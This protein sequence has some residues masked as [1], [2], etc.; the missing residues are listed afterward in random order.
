MAASPTKRSMDYARKRGW[1]PGVVERWIPQVRRRS[2]LF[3]GIDLVL[4]DDQPGL[5]GVQAT[6]GSNVAARVTKLSG[7]DDMHT[8]LERGLRLEVWGWRKAGPRGK[9]KRWAV[10]RVRASLT[11]EGAIWWQEVSE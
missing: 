6:S 11:D 5:L 3:G 4:L 1:V 7:L 9:A 10:R 2:D 8:W